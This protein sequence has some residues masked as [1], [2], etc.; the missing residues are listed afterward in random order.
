MC[1]ILLF[2]NIVYE[3]KFVIIYFM[4]IDWMVVFF[5][6]FINKCWLLG[7][8]LIWMW[9]LFI[10]LIIFDK[11]VMIIV[12][13][14]LNLKFKFLRCIFFKNRFEKLIFNVFDLWII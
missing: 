1:G 8:D 2:G 4:N 14:V 9:V 12:F 7:G 6:F 5:F 3:F 10:V 11:L 13:Y